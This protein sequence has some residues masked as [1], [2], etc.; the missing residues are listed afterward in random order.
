LTY[1]NDKSITLLRAPKSLR[2]NLIFIRAG[3]GN[4]WPFGA[5][6]QPESRNFDIAA[7][8]FSPPDEASALFRHADF[9]LAGGLSKYHAAQKFLQETLL[10]NH[11]KYFW[12]VDDDLEFQFSA[13]DFINFCAGQKFS[14]AQP[15]LTADSFFTFQITRHH[16][17]MLFRITNYVETM[18]PL[19]EAS[20]LKSVI[21]IF[22]RSI[23]SYGLDIYW[24]SRM[25][26]GQQAAIV[27]AFQMRHTRPITDAGKFYQYLEA[28]GINRWAELQDM[29]RFMNMQEYRIFPLSMCY[30]NDIITMPILPQDIP[31]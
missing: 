18:C 14:V 3:A 2:R 26:P 7:S 8:Y 31:T 28:T 23:S 25:A 20:H 27:D 13:D 29:L 10:L 11:Y 4:P 12:F 30:I 22:D 15:A 9:I 17:G 24:S 19:F 5:N 16:P 21:N 6:W 1:R